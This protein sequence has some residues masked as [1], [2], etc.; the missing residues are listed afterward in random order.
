MAS[1][2][3]KNKKDKLVKK[4]TRELLQDLKRQMEEQGAI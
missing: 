4:Y 1:K 2:R 3:L